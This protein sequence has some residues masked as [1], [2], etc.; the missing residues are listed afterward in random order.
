MC[1][2]FPPQSPPQHIPAL[3]SEERKEGNRVALGCQP[4]PG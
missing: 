3:L 2:V 1:L 4:G